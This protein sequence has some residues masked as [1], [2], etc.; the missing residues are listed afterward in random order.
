MDFF[1]KLF[2]NTG[3]MSADSGLYL[4]VQPA[5]CAE[6]VRVRLDQRNDFSLMDDGTYYARKLV[7]ANDWRCNQTVELE[8]T[9]NKQRSSYTT[10]IKGGTLVTAEDYDAWAAQSEGE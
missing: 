9:F 8:V 1:K 2:S 4:Y 7:R 6:V 5:R 10:E 3:R